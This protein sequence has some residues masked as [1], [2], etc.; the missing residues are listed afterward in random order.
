VKRSRIPAPLALVA[1]TS[2]LGGCGVINHID[3]VAQANDLE[4]TGRPAEAKV[5]ELWET[6]MW[7]NRDPVVG[8]LLEVHPPE[9]EPYEARTKLLVSGLSIPQVQPGAILPVRFDPSNPNRVSLDRA[10]MRG[11][12]APRTAAPFPMP[13]PLPRAA[14]IEPEKQRL[15]ATGVPGTITILKAFPLGLFDADGRPAYDLILRVEVAGH[16]P[17]EGPTR[18][19]VAKEREHY[20]H[21]GQELPIKADPQNPKSFAVDWDKLEEVEE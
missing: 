16:P 13:T 4:R 2:T 18:S 14:D 11:G 5:L 12:F 21:E 7:V 1:L 20:F 8:F 19:A 15:L 9:G 6:G 3:G 10:A 17:V